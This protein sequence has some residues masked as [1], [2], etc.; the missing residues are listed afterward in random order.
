MFIVSLTYIRPLSE[1]DAFI[2]E[3]IAYL[4]KHYRLGHFQLSGPKVPRTG[5]VIV[6]TV[7]DRETLDNLLSEDPF[8]REQLAEYQVIEFVPNRS[9]H[10]LEC[11]V[12]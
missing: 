5:G 10:D 6:A 2:P 3:H 4:D 1:V 11:M 7:G 9:S 8:Y 12:E